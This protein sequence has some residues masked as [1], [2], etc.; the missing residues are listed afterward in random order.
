MAV[1]CRCN[2]VWPLFDRGRYHGDIF[3][4][5]YRHIHDRQT[6]NQGYLGRDKAV[7]GD[8]IGVTGLLGESAYG[9]ELLKAGHKGRVNRF[10]RRYLEPKPPYE[11]WKELT[12][13]GITNA[14]MDISDGLIID[15]KG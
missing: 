3:R 7:T 1:S 12:K 9:L 2:G 11:T 15:L 13:S 5:L 4:P 6:D 8:L 10:I 14:M